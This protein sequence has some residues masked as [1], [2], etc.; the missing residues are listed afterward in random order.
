VEAVAVVVVLYFYLQPNKQILQLRPLQVLHRLKV[1]RQILQY[2]L[3]SPIYL[4]WLA[5]IL[6]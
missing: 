6:Y 1:R 4:N 3:Q 2:Q 5:L